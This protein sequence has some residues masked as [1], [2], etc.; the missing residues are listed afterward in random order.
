MK[1]CL[2]LICDPDKAILFSSLIN[3]YKKI[4]K[5]SEVTIITN[6]KSSFLF[7]KYGLIKNILINSIDSLDY[8]IFVNL[9]LNPTSIQIA[10]DVKAKNKLGIIGKENNKYIY[11]NDNAKHFYECFY[12]DK[13]T[14]KNA[15]QIIFKACDLTW[16]GEG[17][18]SPGVF[19]KVKKTKNILINIKNGI[20]KDFLIKKFNSKGIQFDTLSFEDNIE[21]S[22]NIAQYNDLITDNM[23][24]CQI[25]ILNG[26]GAQFISN[27][28]NYNIEFFNKGCYHDL[29][30]IKL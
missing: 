1:I 6:E 2:S 12:E 30:S 22:K 26:V 9:S 18:Y 16:N 4:Y 15:F 29:L 8:D 14:N 3:K 23:L 5:N 27:K 24:L 11:S 7:K 19:Y 17:C 10:N 25:A 28:T 13:K 20:V 21:N